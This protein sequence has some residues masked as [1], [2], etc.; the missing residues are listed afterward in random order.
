MQKCYNWTRPR[1]AS[2]AKSLPTDLLRR[3]GVLGPKS[4]CPACDY[5][6]SRL[7]AGD[8]NHCA[9]QRDLEQLIAWISNPTVKRQRFQG[10]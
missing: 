10:G 4:K 7:V 8:L 6:A 3:G 1:P 9:Y 5:C 2:S